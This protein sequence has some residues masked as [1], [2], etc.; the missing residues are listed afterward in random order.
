MSPRYAVYFVPAA[1]SALYRFGSA[2]LGYDCYTGKEIDFPAALPLDPAAWREVTREPR[3][4]GFHAT[5]KAPFHLAYGFDEAAL[6]DAFHLLCGSMEGA[7]F[8][9]VVAVV[10]GFIAIIPSGPEPTVDRLAADC[11]TAFDRFRA[12]LSEHDRER[13]LAARLSEQQAQNLERWGYPYVFEDFRLHLTL[14]GRL[15]AERQSHVLP[16]LREQFAMACSAAAVPIDAIA[17][18]RQ[19]DAQSRFRV[20]GR[21]WIAAARP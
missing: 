21:A 15:S 13:R 9:P 1:Q 12:P 10:E 8:T 6:F 14:T 16:F 19:D 7:A 11:V 2:L 4:Y 17:L 5:L 20:L 3:R 18:L